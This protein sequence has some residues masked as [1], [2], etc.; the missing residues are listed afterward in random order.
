[1]IRP[2]SALL[3]LIASLG[4]TQANAQVPAPRESPPGN[5]LPWGSTVVIGRDSWSDP[6]VHF[7]TVKD[8]EPAIAKFKDRAARD[9]DV[10]R[11][12]LEGDRVLKI[13]DEGICDG[14]ANCL[15]HRLQDWWPKPNYYAVDVTRGEGGWTYLIRESDGLVVRVAALPVLSP[16]GRYAIASDPSVINGG[17]QTE[18]LDMRTDPPTVHPVG[19]TSMCPGHSGRATY[20]GLITLGPNPIWLGSSRVVFNAAHVNFED[21]PRTVG[22]TLRIVD[23]KPEWEC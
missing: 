13:F 11:L 17:G 22:L 9:G 16:D 10:L 23:G 3:V 6:D 7:R 12:R 21:G 8:P 15:R 5:A 14:F 20:I 2:V 4:A 1:M 19:S 18:L